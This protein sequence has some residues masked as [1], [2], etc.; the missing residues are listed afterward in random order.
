M[1]GDINLL[2]KKRS[3]DITKIASG[4]I[5]G[6]I[7]LL[8]VVA[9]VF[10]YMP[11]M[12][13][14]R[15]K[16]D[17]E[18]TKSEIE[19]IA[20]T[21]EDFKKVADELFL[22]VKKNAIFSNIRSENLAFSGILEDFESATPTSIVLDELSYT[23]GFLNIKGK[24]PSPLE[25]SQFMVNLRRLNNVILVSLST[26][27]LESVQNPEDNTTNFYTF[28]LSVV[29]YED[30]EEDLEEDIDS[31]EETIDESNSEEATTEETITEEGAQ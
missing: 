14:R 28:D 22:L 12:E 15:I 6:I 11:N 21:N 23:S 19:K 25:L 9:V 7:I 13:K 27:E 20:V 31:Q 24:T 17:I 18:Y 26:M 1:R 30:V 3:G 4:F 2:P 5:L 8:A 16:K 10:V 29:F